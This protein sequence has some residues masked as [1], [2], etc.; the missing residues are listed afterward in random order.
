MSQYDIIIIGAGA[1]ALSAAVQLAGKKRVL[2]I[3][4]GP[5]PGGKMG[6]AQVEGVEFDTGPS[7]LTMTDVVASVFSNAGLDYRD[8]LEL[9]EVDGFSYLWPDKTALN[10]RFAKGDTLAEIEK[11]FGTKHA[12][13][14]K[15]FLDYTEEIWNA[16]APN[17]VYGEAPSFGGAIKLGMTKFRELMKI[18][19]M[20]SMAAAIESRVSEAHLRDLL[21]RYATYNGSHPWRAPATLN[22]IAWVELGLG[23]YGIKGGLF[24]LAEALEKA[25]TEKGA[26]F[27]YNTRV[28]NILTTG[29]KVRGVMCGDTKFEA[30]VVLCN[31]DVSHL[32]HD[33]LEDSPI[34]EAGEPSMSG[35]TGV[36]KARRVPRPSHTVLFP[37][38]PYQQEFVDI[39]DRERLP[40]EPTIYLCAQEKSHKRN[41]W[42]DH[43]PIFAMINAPYVKDI[44]SAP[45]VEEVADQIKQRLLAF[46]LIH[47]EDTWVWM[48]RPQDLA[49]QFPGSRGSIYGASS[50]SQFSAFQRPPNRVKDLPGLFLASGSAHPG[51]GVPMCLLSG[52]AAAKQI[53][54]D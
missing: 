31:A 17:F 34:K 39:F 14:F 3:E 28:T 37:A 50:N 41:G 42:E 40:E 7:V 4:A 36:I 20:R 35:W 5:D 44:S 25:A 47:P 9:I 26:E 49:A 33:L 13:E 24:R 52:T 23:C 45:P 43:E 46:D 10:I 54:S 12:E 38:R 53:F 48:R 22:C 27:V 21:L 2:V 6:R 32:I 16:A 15:G 19:P 51:G 30:P 1:G 8:Y 11:V 18:D 29:K